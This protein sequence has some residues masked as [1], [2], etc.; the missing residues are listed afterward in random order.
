MKRRRRHSHRNFRLA[1][2]GLA[3]NFISRRPHS[4]ANLSSPHNDFARSSSMVASTRCGGRRVFATG[5]IDPLRCAR[6]SHHPMGT[7]E[8]S[9]NLTGPMITSAAFMN[10]SMM[11][12]TWW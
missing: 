2:Q 10:V 9:R 3:R 4:V 12:M 7:E 1:L 8:Q 5:G 6:G 11:L